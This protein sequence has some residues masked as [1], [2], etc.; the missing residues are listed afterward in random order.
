MEAVFQE[1]E[2]RAIFQGRDVAV[3]NV[4]RGAWRRSQAMLVRWVESC[5]ANVV[6]A[7]A[8]AHIGWE[9]SR[10]F[11]LWFYLIYKQAGL[12]RWLNGFV[13]PRY[14]LSDDA[15]RQLEQFGEDL[16]QRKRVKWYRSTVV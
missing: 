1:S 12:P 6:G 3:L 16:A 13:Q 15:F 5:G 8:F 10:L 7:R 4:C 11:S 9:P 14:G 2:S